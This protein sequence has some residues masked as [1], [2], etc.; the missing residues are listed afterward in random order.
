MDIHNAIIKLL[1]TKHIE[2]ERK[3]NDHITSYL[4]LIN[5]LSKEVKPISTK[6]L[7]KD[8]INGYSILNSE[9]YFPKDGS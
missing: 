2:V 5:D 6:W 9:K 3:S 7:K 4:K 8:L 1:Q